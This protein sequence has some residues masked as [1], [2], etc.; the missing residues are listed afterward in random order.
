VVE[1]RELRSRHRDSN[2]KAGKVDIGRT[3]SLLGIKIACP[4]I[5]RQV[6]LIAQTLEAFSISWTASTVTYLSGSGDFG[7]SDCSITRRIMSAYS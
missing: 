5:L 2:L 3:L 1:I 4:E 6:L 7:S